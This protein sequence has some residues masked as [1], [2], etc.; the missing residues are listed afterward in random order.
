MN[1]TFFMVTQENMQE[2]GFSWDADLPEI[3]RAI[4]LSDGVLTSDALERHF[5]CIDRESRFV[6]VDVLDYGGVIAWFGDENEAKG[7][8][9]GK[10]GNHPAIHFL[11]EY[12][13]SI[14]APPLLYSGENPAVKRARLKESIT[15]LIT[16]EQ[17]D[18]KKI[19]EFGYDDFIQY[20]KQETNH[21]GE[22][23]SPLIA[24]SVGSGF[25]AATPSGFSRMPAGYFAEVGGKAGLSMDVLEYLGREFPQKMQIVNDPHFLNGPNRSANLAA[26]LPI[27]EP[28]VVRQAVP[29]GLAAA[30]SKMAAAASMPKIS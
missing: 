2:Y 11:S 19:A 12:G 4:G 25:F 6:P 16:E 20:V 3:A 30:V 13:Q 27:K 5:V 21:Y 17:P 9:Y 8:W 24:L 26:V 1:R 28:P 18:G 22:T 10:F 14:D 29:R 7:W 15:R 23:S